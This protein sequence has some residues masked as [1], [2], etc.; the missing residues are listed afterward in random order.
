MEKRHVIN[1]ILLMLV[2]IIYACFGLAYQIQF[3]SMFRIIFVMIYASFIVLDLYLALKG[4][5]NY[6][7]I[8]SRVGLLVI[9]V[10]MLFFVYGSP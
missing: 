9:I 5:G 4:K 7:G 6:R 2:L 1:I 3:Y 10:I 8:I